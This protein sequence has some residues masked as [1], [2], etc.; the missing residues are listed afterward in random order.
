M[1]KWPLRSVGVVGVVLL[2][3]ACSV[4]QVPPKAR[5]PQAARVNMTE[6]QRVRDGVQSFLTVW[7]VDRNLEKA[8]AA[9]GAAAFSNE[10]ILQA[11]CAD[12]IKPEDRGSESARR[13][14]VQKFL[15]DFMPQKR[16]ATL[17]EVLSRDAMS[18]LMDQLG[19]RLVNDPKTDL[20]ALAKLTTEQL[21]VGESRD[22]EYLRKNLPSSFYVSF[23]P[24][25]QGMIYFLWVPQ[26]S[27]WRIYHASLVCM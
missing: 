9:F 13:A 23:V 4:A 11:P 17:R 10:A 27:D 1:T 26:G 8:T 24:V 22:T 5:A 3:Q 6:Q 15:Q 14:G 20:F 2:T 21:P 18:A 12:S 16:V 25:G 19:T 7:L